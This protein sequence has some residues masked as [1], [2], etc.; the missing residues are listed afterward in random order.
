MNKRQKKKHMKKI[1]DRHNYLS[2]YHFCWGRQ[3]GK[4]YFINQMFMAVY[5][6]RYKPFDRVKKYLEKN[7]Y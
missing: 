5:S 7:S 2:Q 3:S 4:T 1:K 6:K